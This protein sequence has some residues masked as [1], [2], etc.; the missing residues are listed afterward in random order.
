[1]RCE[2]LV[3]YISNFN[4]IEKMFEDKLKSAWASP[5]SDDEVRKI[6]EEKA[7]LYKIGVRSIP[8]SNFFAEKL[9]ETMVLFI[10]N[11]TATE[12]ERPDLVPITRG[13]GEYVTFRIVV[14]AEVWSLY[15]SE[16]DVRK[17][18]ELC[19]QVVKDVRANNFFEEIYSCE[20]D[21]FEN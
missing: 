9:Y 10:G 5:K 4:E 13:V 17:M 15:C 8:I 11:F 16:R 18:A 19:R 12:V 6:R 2:T 14:K 1:M 3:K 21:R 20:L 7:K